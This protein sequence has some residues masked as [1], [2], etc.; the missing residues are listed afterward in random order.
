MKINHITLFLCAVLLAGMTRADDAAQSDLAARRAAASERF[1]MRTGGFIV[2]VHNTTGGIYF[3]NCQSRVPISTLPNAATRLQT[4]SWIPCKVAETSDVNLQTMAKRLKDSKWEVAV[5]LIDNGELP[6]QLVQP[7]G[8]WALVN[9]SA[10]AVGNPTGD[11][12]S[13]RVE[14]EMLRAAA[15]LFGCG[16]SLN[17]GGVARPVQDMEE[18]DHCLSPSLPVD[19]FTTM[20][21]FAPKFGITVGRRCYY[22][23]AVEEGWAPPPVNKYQRSAWDRVRAIPT[24][25]MKI[26]FDPK[27]GR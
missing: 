17:A 9:V 2:D 3:V 6:V 21:A 25:P 19:V 22:S 16:Y 13:S 1:R 27:K 12:L 10:L 7:E 23:K 5:V 4:D 20:Q 18:L 8:R 24:E 14:K 26:E 15:M 11:V